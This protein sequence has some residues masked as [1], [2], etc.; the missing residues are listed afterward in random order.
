[1]N[2]VIVQIDK[3]RSYQTLVYKRGKDTFKKSAY[4]QYERDIA[5]Q[6]G[7]LK[8][9]EHKKPIKA[10]IVFKSH[11]RAIGDNDNITKPILD[12]LESTNKI[13]N[14]KYIVDLHIIKQ[15]GYKTSS[16]EI[17]LLEVNSE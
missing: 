5:I 1:M 7:S 3:I 11:T 15:F 10:T 12:I 16:I 17:E 14:D 13:S 6:L 8:P 9:I 4:R 2:K